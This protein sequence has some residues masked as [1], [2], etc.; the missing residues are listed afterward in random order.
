MF[1]ARLLGEPVGDKFLDLTGCDVS[2]LKA[3]VLRK[4]YV[5]VTRT[6]LG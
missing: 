6:L 1:V 4:D 3:S 5:E 2:S